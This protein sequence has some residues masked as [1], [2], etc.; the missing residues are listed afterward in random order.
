MTKTELVDMISSSAN[1]SRSDASRSL[2]TMLK[3]IMTTLKK[4]EKVMLVDFGTFYVAKRKA[5]TVRNPGGV[6]EEHVLP[7]RKVA[8]FT[9]GIT[10]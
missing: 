7:L 8:R 6:S 5:R 3:A 2:D 1:I 4:G 10:L 9:S